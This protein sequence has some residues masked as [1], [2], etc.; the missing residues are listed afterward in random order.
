[1]RLQIHPNYRI[2]HHHHNKLRIIVYEPSKLSMTAV[3]IRWSRT[4]IDIAVDDQ[5]HLD[6]CRYSKASL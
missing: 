5:S 1:M 4:V 3:V 6:Q 2:K